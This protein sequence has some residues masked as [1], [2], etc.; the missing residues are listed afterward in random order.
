MEQDP[1]LSRLIKE[2]GVARAPGGFTAAVMDR[3]A[4]E[5]EK[6]V[7]KPLIGRT[8]RILILLFVV[9]VVVITLVY[10]EPGG[11]LLQGEGIPD[12]NWKLPAF[13][14]DL[15]FISDLKIPSGIAAALVALFILV[16]S[17]AG[18]RRR[19]FVL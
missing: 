6:K 17:D 12:L 4:A 13:N 1:K 3:I 11:S 5:P 10:S 7:Y 16:L 15:Q 2:H 18:F 14:L 9:A 19:R 8:G